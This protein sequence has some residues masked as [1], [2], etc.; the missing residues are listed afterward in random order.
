MA[1]HAKISAS[2]MYRT[3]SC[4]GWIKQSAGIKQKPSVYAAEG[5]AAHELGEVCLKK[6]M[7]AIDQLGKTFNG[8]E[9]TNE[10][11]LAVQM[12]LDTIRAD[13]GESKGKKAL[14]IEEKFRLNWLY[15]GLFG[16][17]DA[18]LIIPEQKKLI[19]YDY[20][21]GK[22]HAVEVEYNPQLMYYALGAIHDKTEHINE[23]ELVVVQPRA[24]HNDGPVR[25]WSLLKW[26]LLAWGHQVLVPAAKLAEEDNPSLFAGDHCK[27]CP[28]LATCP[29]QAKKAYEIAKQDFNKPIDLPDPKSLSPADIVKVMEAADLFGNWANA[30]KAHA[31]EQ[32]ERGVKLPG[33]K[34]VKKKSNRKWK[35][36]EQAGIELAVL[37][38]EDAYEKKVLSVAKAE[39][40]AKKNNEE[41]DS[42]LWEK[43][44]TGC[45]LAPASDKRKEVSA[46][47]PAIDFL[48]ESVFN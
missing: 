6:D 14:L 44:D 45:V 7:N 46:T 25:R 2:S 40:L 12:Y 38:G 30:V 11:A 8:Y 31:Q 34:L 1:K 20:K 10:M 37:Y 21:H 39:K 28:S 15:P 18:C 17:N 22:G 47:A 36:E 26:E 29:A 33:Y 23:V 48:D 32:A 27:F 43:P 9:V 24:P 16:T 19:I 5:T 3:I 42:K 13:I 4:P 41:L 35:D